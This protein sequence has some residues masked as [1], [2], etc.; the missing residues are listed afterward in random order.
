MNNR[1]LKVY[2]LSTVLVYAESHVKSRTFS[3][4]NIIENPTSR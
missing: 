3:H 1:L 4:T 2:L